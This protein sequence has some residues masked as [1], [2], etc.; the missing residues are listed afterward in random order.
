MFKFWWVRA[1]AMLV[2][3]AGLSAPRTTLAQAVQPAPTQVSQ[4]THE[5]RFADQINAFIERDRV[6]PPPT[7]R[8]PLLRRQHLP[9][10]DDS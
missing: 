9:F 8:D 3:L 2:F 1:S 6:S 7:W 4:T 5:I 10:V